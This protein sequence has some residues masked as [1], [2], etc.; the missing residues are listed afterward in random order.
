MNTLH[1]ETSL[2][3]AR[4]YEEL[5]RALEDIPQGEERQRVMRRMI[6]QLQAVNGRNERLNGLKESWK[7]GR[8]AKLWI[9]IATGALAPV[10]FFCIFIWTSLWVE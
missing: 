1:P 2:E 7:S 10:V 5:H 8:P 4:L 3:E 6:R 9:W